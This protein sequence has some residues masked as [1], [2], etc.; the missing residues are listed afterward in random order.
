MLKSQTTRGLMN[1]CNSYLKCVLFI[2]PSHINPFLA[3]IPCLGFLQ[4]IRAFHS[5]IIAGNKKGYTRGYAC[6][7]AYPIVHSVPSGAQR[8][9]NAVVS[10]CIFLELSLAALHLKPNDLIPT[11][12]FM[13]CME[14]L[15]VSWLQCAE[16]TALLQIAEAQHPSAAS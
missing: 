10:L 16:G 12:P 8:V 3:C 9:Y 2:P 15:S 4:R 13:G 14:H 1:R 5:A 6:C 7:L 11:I